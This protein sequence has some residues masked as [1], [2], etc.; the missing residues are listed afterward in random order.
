MDPY[1]EKKAKSENGFD[2]FLEVLRG[3]QE[4]IEL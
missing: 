1:K 3:R 4:G 2:I